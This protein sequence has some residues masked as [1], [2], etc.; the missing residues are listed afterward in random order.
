MK[1][2]FLFL[3]KN[4]VGPKLSGI[5]IAPRII[6]DAYPLKTENTKAKMIEMTGIASR[7]KVLTS[8]TFSLA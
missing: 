1:K 3:M 4:I 6:N 2:F 8:N 5:N 7:A